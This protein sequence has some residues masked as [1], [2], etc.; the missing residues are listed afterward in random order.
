MRIL[1]TL[2]IVTTS[3]VVSLVG[4][5]SDSDGGSANKGGGANGG[6][7][8]GGSANNGGSA[9]SSL[10]QCLGI[11]AEFTP[12]EF[13]AQTS[14]G[15]ACASDV[16]SV[17][18]NDLPVVGGECGK[19]CLGMGDDAAQAVCVAG[20]IQDDLASAKSK[21]L[22]EGCMACYTGDI[23]CARTN[24]LLKCGLDPTSDTCLMCRIENGC[25]A[26]FYACSG[27]PLPGTS[28]GSGGEGGS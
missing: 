5:G 7:A 2:L 22:S 28:G 8:N 15:K 24:C 26:G 20:C 1:S 10:A 25:V 21:P 23:A 6:G 17:C 4:C 19:G 14:K 12:A 13:L 9:G 27:L 16:G 3:A 18:D 11:N